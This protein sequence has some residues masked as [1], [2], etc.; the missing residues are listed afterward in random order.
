MLGVVQTHR[1]N[2][3]GWCLHPKASPIMISDWSYTPT[4]YWGEFAKDALSGKQFELKK[5]R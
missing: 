3:T 5:T 1:L 2:W 4:P